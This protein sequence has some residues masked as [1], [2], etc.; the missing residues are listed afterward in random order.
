MK[1]KTLEKIAIEYYCPYNTQNVIVLLILA[2]FILLFF[3][4]TCTGKV[5][6]KTH[7]FTVPTTS[8][9]ISPLC[10]KGSCVLTANKKEHGK[11]ELVTSSWSSWHREGFLVRSITC[12]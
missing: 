9:T 8:Q 12:Q 2:D 4:L 5:K 11:I 6:L 10:F 7:H 1:I 3:E